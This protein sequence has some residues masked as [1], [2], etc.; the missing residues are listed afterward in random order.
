MDWTHRTLRCGLATLSEAPT[1]RNQLKLLTPPVVRGEPTEDLVLSSPGR[2]TTPSGYGSA[3]LQAL[4]RSCFP[5]PRQMVRWCLIGADPQSV[6]GLRLATS[7]PAVLI[8]SQIRAGVVSHPTPH[9]LSRSYYLWLTSHYKSVMHVGVGCP[10]AAGLQHRIVV[11]ALPD[12]TVPYPFGPA[13]ALAALTLWAADLPGISGGFL[14]RG[15]HP[16]TPLIPFI[17]PYM[18]TAPV[19]QLLT[20]FTKAG[21]MSLT[22]STEGPFLF[23]R[24]DQDP[25]VSHRRFHVAAAAF[26]EVPR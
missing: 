25:S 24:Q 14:Q 4:P 10:V 9:G 7:Q 8:W 20:D 16:R 1:L 6:Q 19:S 12:L 18:P 15:S 21:P 2:G 11:R 17:R 13:Q 23:P 22:L 3:V 26:W 5:V